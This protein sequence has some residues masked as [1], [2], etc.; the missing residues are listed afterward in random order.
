MYRRHL[1]K[2]FGLTGWRK[3]AWERVCMR[4]AVSEQ[5]VLSLASSIPLPGV[6]LSLF[7]FIR[8]EVTI[9]WVATLGG[10][11]SWAPF[12]QSS[13]VQFPIWGFCPPLS[14]WEGG[15]VQAVCFGVKRGQPSCPPLLLFQ[16]LKFHFSCAVLALGFHSV[17]KI[18]YQPCKVQSW[19]NTFMYL[20]SFDLYNSPLR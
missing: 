14:S 19:Q 20:I 9:C 6:M 15:R 11:L 17:F 4:Q 18:S 12:A 2:W 1:I 10:K 3:D 7:C 5:W 16:C 8:V 13:T